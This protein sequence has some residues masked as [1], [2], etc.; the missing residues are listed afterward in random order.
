MKKVFFLLSV[1]MI[2]AC[3]SLPV[4]AGSFSVTYTQINTEYHNTHLEDQGE[5]GLYTL[6]YL[7]FKLGLAKGYDDPIGEVTYVVNS[8]DWAYRTKYTGWV[9]NSYGCDNVVITPIN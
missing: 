9:D 7:R 5:M 1:V 6:G 2:I 3:M 4:F 8:D